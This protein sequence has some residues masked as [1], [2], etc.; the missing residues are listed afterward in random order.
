L[1]RIERPAE[2]ANIIVAN[3]NGAPVRIRDIARVED[4]VEEARSLARLDGKPA[5][6][7]E[8]R[9]QSGTNTLEVIQAVKQ[10]IEELKP[11]LPPDFSILRRRPVHLHRGILQGRSGT[12]A[13][14]RLV[15]RAGGAA[16]YTELALHPHRRHRDPDL[17]HL[18]VHND[19]PDGVHS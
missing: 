18:H 13:A 2:F 14:R 17:D 3:M 11:T 8:I 19:E 12:P 16:V 5:V 15:R 4:G 7:L 10:R 9:K 1:G 6:V